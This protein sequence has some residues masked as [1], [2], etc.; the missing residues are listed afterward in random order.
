MF[1]KIFAVSILSTEA[2]IAQGPWTSLTDLAEASRRLFI[3]VGITE[4]QSV[5]E[6]HLEE[7]SARTEKTSLSPQ[8]IDM[9]KKDLANY[10]NR[11]HGQ[12][13]ALR[14][15]LKKMKVYERSYPEEGSLVGHG[16][17][18]V[19]DLRHV[20]YRLKHRA[21]DVHRLSETLTPS[22]KLHT[23]MENFRWLDFRWINWEYKYLYNTLFPLL[24]PRQSQDVAWALEQKRRRDVTYYLRFLNNFKNQQEVFLEEDFPKLTTAEGRKTLSKILEGSKFSKKEY[25]QC[26]P[27]VYL[28]MAPSRNLPSLSLDRSTSLGQACQTWLTSRFD[29][30][31]QCRKLRS[32]FVK[33]RPLPASELQ[34]LHKI[35]QHS[36]KSLILYMKLI[37]E[38]SLLGL[39][40]QAIFD[41]QVQ[42]LR[43]ILVARIDQASTWRQIRQHRCFWAPTLDNFYPEAPQ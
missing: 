30:T 24:W 21:K 6:H 36:Q 39:E 7:L 35:L 23:L 19:K 27:P 31:A 12:I 16:C 17:H 40:R 14:E 5:L 13:Q 28:L 2:A 33:G 26:Y 20:K 11:L 25:F 9:I 4:E 42:N 3:A 15:Y 22:T 10:E 37:A 38:R 43:P 1:L 8:H 29:T 34:K 32:Y 18:F 41:G